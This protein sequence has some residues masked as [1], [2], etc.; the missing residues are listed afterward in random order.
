M[1]LI[2]VKCK[3]APDYVKEKYIVRN[4]MIIGFMASSDCFGKDLIFKKQKEQALRDSRAIAKKLN[5]TVS[6]SS[7]STRS[8]DASKFQV[9]FFSG[10]TRSI[11]EIREE[12]DAAVKEYQKLGY[13]VV[14]ELPWL[15]F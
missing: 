7:M 2:K 10:G 8:D 12:E 9:S 4:G 1:K 13:K 5:T 3:D 11:G 15:Y 6:L 14:N